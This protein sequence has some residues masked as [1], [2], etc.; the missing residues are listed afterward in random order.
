MLSMLRDPYSSCKTPW[1]WL[2]EPHSSPRQE[3]LSREKRWRIRPLWTKYHVLSSYQVHGA[4]AHL[5]QRP[6]ADLDRALHAATPLEGPINDPLRLK[7][8]YEFFKGQLRRPPDCLLVQA[9]AL[10][11][12]CGSCMVPI[13]QVATYLPYL[14][15]LNYLPDLQPAP[16]LQR[17]RRRRWRH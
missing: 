6:C 11:A 10:T 2:H 14:R 8:P 9:I 17:R 4:F 3:R 13:I 5:Q 1:R 15:F 16:S 7:V 12:I